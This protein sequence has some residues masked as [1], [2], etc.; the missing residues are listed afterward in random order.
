MGRI[1]RVV[2]LLDLSDAEPAQVGIARFV[3]DAG[4]LPQN[5]NYAAKADYAGLLFDRPAPRK[6]A[7]SR[8]DA[9]DAARRAVCFVQA[10]FPI[11][12]ERTLA[13]S[14]SNAGSAL[15]S[16]ERDRI[17][18]YVCGA[19]VGPCKDSRMPRIR[20]LV[21]QGMSLDEAYMQATQERDAKN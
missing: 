2:P 5:V 3:K 10:Q 1:I 13:N 9:I 20:E 19:G 16:G 8:S 11:N 18:I 12:D 15:P 4:S 17:A 14:R 6:G 21:A 7:A